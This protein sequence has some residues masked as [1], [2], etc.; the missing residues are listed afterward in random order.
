MTR[1]WYTLIAMTC[2]VYHPCKKPLNAQSLPPYVSLP[3]MRINATKRPV[4]TLRD[5]A[6]KA[7]WSQK[8]S[9]CPARQWLRFMR[10]AMLPFNIHHRR[11]PAMVSHVVPFKKSRQ[12]HFETFYIYFFLLFTFWNQILDILHG[13]AGP[14]FFRLY[15]N[16]GWCPNLPKMK[17]NSPNIIVG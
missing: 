14:Y 1:G 9:H 16:N 15:N 8:K 17:S 13:T 11:Y 4:S 7:E 12:R 10:P 6:Q 3:T 5:N 2:N